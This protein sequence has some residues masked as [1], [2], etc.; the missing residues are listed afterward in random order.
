M[1]AIL[2][3]LNA[4]F[5]WSTGTA[6][7]RRLLELRRAGDPIQLSDL[8]REPIPPEQNA[9]VYL[10]RADDDLDAI[11][12]EL[13]AMYPKTAEPSRVLSAE[14]REKL[15]KLLSAYPRV[16]P[17][18]EQAAACPD[19]DPQIDVTLPTARFIETAMERPDKHRLLARV[20]RARSAL[21]I[22]RGQLDDALANQVLLLRL[23]RHW[24]RE[25][26]LIGCLITNSCEQT[27][28]SCVN[29]VLQAGPLSPPA[30][31]ALV[32]ELALHDTLEGYVWAMRSERS[33]SLS[34]ARQFPGAGDWLL[35][36][37]SNDLQLRLIALFDQYIEQTLKPFAEVWGSNKP[38]R[39]RRGVPNPYAA[40][41]T[42]LEPSLNSV[43][44]P[45]ERVRAMS[46][47]LRVL[48]ALQTR[49]AAENDQA[50]K[51]ADLGLPRESTIDPYSGE[52]L[53]LKKLPEGWLVYSIGMNLADDGGT[54]DG[55]TDIGAGP[56]S[57]N[58][59]VKKP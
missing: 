7:E 38:E 40:V 22:A 46:R 34:S 6:L 19:F 26:L 55:I 24:R 12:K 23:A 44:E 57:N 30:R 4:F 21:L 43:R 51:L 13:L 3:V 36:G 20:L 5:V 14:E 11:H 1:I 18:L 28:M 2:L 42:L 45:A 25:P 16:M 39:V 32:T 8:A 53:H 27:A 50:P 33:L 9:D 58:A 15:D 52:P 48:S 31:Q 41:V 47:S 10:R 59:P 54:L 29:Q 37:F 17:L 35:R 56:K 49:R